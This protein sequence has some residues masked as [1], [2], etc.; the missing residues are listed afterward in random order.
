MNILVGAI[1]AAIR[2][3][4]LPIAVIA[5]VVT[6]GGVL[7]DRDKGYTSKQIENIVEDLEIDE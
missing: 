3:V 5:D 2:I 4:T 1:R 7:T 6:L